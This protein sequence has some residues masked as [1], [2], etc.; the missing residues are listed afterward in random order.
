MPANFILGRYS[1]E[2]RQGMYHKSPGFGSLNNWDWDDVKESIQGLI[3]SGRIEI[4]EKGSCKGKIKAV[5]HLS[6]VADHL[7]KMS[8]AFHGSLRSIADRN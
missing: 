4:V 7:F 3:A 1:Q 5:F 8:L 2:I 6:M